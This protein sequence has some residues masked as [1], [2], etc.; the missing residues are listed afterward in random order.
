MLIE[1]WP[2]TQV[3]VSSRLVD[4]FQASEPPPSALSLHL[5]PH[6]HRGCS[7]HNSFGAA[8]GSPP[9]SP[10]FFS[11]TLLWSRKAIPGAFVI[12]LPSRNPSIKREVLID[13]LGLC[14]NFKVFFFSAS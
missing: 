4:W 12:L 5:P 13:V 1:T 3:E 10:P 6:R 8:A 2:G 7:M 14:R 11:L 9:S